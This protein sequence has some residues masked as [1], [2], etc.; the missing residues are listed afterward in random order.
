[1]LVPK[2]FHS[3]FSPTLRLT[4]I[5]CSVSSMVVVFQVAPLS[6][7]Y[8]M[9]CIWAWVTAEPMVSVIVFPSS[10]LSIVKYCSSK[11]VW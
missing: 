2:P 6:V 1:M 9:F 7:E 8:E 5:T 10:R 3:T 4:L 11:G